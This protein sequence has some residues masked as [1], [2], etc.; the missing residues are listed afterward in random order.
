MKFVALAIIVL[1]FVGCSIH[2]FELAPVPYTITE[3]ITCSSRSPSSVQLLQG[4]SK[5]IKP[6]TRCKPTAALV[7]ERLDADDFPVQATVDERQVQR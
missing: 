4:G 3:T 2:H 5:L 6:A 7:K 1:S